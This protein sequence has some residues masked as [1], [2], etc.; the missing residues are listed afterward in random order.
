ME[1]L[2]KALI[3]GVLAPTVGMSGGHELNAERISRIWTEIGPKYGYRALEQTPDGSAARL[4]GIS[5]EDS[6]VIQPPILQV[7]E[8]IQLTTDLSAEKAQDILKVIARLLGVSEFFNMGIR[9]IYHAPV[10]SSDG[11]DFVL[12]RVI[13]KNESELG[14]LQT[15]GPFWAGVK[16]V[17]N[18]GSGQYTL[19]IEPLLRD[20]K[21]LFLDLD[22]QLEGPANLD[23]LKLKAQEAETYMT[24]AVNEYLTRLTMEG[25]V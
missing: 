1:M 11:R 17:S 25:G 4:K 9:L 3:A 20:E 8:V 12:H 15:G 13:R 16:Y 19:L 10:P 24:Q 14:A 18:F 5:D 23:S 6:V 2:P 21:F 22:M 7:R